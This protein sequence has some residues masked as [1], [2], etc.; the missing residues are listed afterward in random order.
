MWDQKF[1]PE[2]PMDS[3]FR[4]FF[5]VCVLIVFA[6]PGVAQVAKMDL[7]RLDQLAKWQSVYRVRTL[8]VHLNVKDMNTPLGQKW[9]QFIRSA[10]GRWDIYIDAYTGLPSLVN[11]SGIEWYRYEEPIEFDVLE[12]MARAFIRKYPLLFGGRFDETWLQVNPIR[13]GFFGETNELAFIDYD[14]IYKG[15]P[16]EGARL[17]FRLNHGR[18][19]QFG[20][21]GFRPVALENFDVIP[22]ISR[23]QA[24][25]ILEDYIGGFDQRTDHFIDG[26]HLII[27]PDTNGISVSPGKQSVIKGG[28]RGTRPTTLEAPPFLRYRL[29]WRL[30]FIRD[31]V[32][33]T[34][35]AHIDA[36]TGA[37]LE[38]FDDNKYGVVKG[39]V[40]PS[41]P[42]VTSETILPLPYADIRDSSGSLLE[43]ANSGGVYGTSSGTVK[44][45]LNG[46]YVKINDNCGSIS[47]STT[48]PGDLNFG[49]SSGTDCTTPGYGG[50]GN[51][52]SARSCFYHVNRIMEKGRAWLPSNNW[53][54][55]QLTS[56]VNI[57]SSCNAYWSPWQGTINFYRSGNG[58]GN[59]GEIAAIFL[60]EWGH[61]L[62]SNDG[63][64]PAELGTGEAYGD[65]VAFL[66]THESCIGP[67][68]LTNNCSG[69]GDSCLSCTGVRDVDY[70]KRA[71]GTPATPSNFIKNR[72]PT[73]SNYQGPC[74]REGHCES[75]VVSE[76]VWDLAARDLP[77][78]G[79]S[80]ATA[81]YIVDRL[82]YLTRTTSGQAFNC[83]N[84]S[85]NG[86]SAS[87]WYQTFL[88]ADDN[89]GDLSNGTPHG[90]EIYSAF[91][92]HG[93]ACGTAPGSSGCTA[94]SAPSLSGSAGNNSA[95]LSWTSVSGATK[96]VIL[97][98]DMGCSA[99]FT[100]VGETTSTS[101]TDSSV[102]N[103]FT[104]YYRVVAIGS[105]GACFSALSNC[106]TIT[107]TAG[108]A[109]YSISGKITSA[110]A[111]LSGV[112]VNYSGTASG[113]VTTDSTGSYTISNLANGTYTITPTKT[114]YT[115]TPVSQDVTV[116]N[117][118][119]TNV[120]FTATASTTDVTLTSGAPV[121]DSVGYQAW[122]Y[123]KIDV[124]AGATKLVFQTTNASADVDLYTRYGSKP[125]LSTYDCR[126][127]TSSGNETCTHNNPTSG[128]WWAGVYGYAAGSYTITATITS[129]SGSYTISGT[130][131]VN[132]SGLS[133]ATVTLSGDASATTTT[134]T[135]GYYE[136]TGVTNG[137]YTVTPS[138]SGY[139]FSPTSRNVNVNDASV[140]G[141]DFTASPVSSDVQL[142]N[143]TPYNDSL[144]ASSRNGTWKYYYVNIA[145]GS[146]NLSIS[147]SNLTADADLYVRYGS[148]PTL[149]SYDCRPYKGGTTTETC[150]FASP[151]GG[152]YWI[153]VTNWDTG[154]ISYTVT[155]S[156]TAPSSDTTPPDTTITSSQCGT[157]ISTNSTTITW[158]GSDNVTPTSNLVYN[159]RID[160]GTWSAYSTATSHTFTSLTD[161][162]HTVEVKAKDEAGNIDPTPASCTFTVD[163]TSTGD[164]ALSSGTP[165][166][167]SMTSTDTWKYYY[168]DVPSDAT[169]L[170]IETTNATADIDLYVR[171]NAKP[172]LSTYDCR[173]YTSSGNETCTFDSSTPTPISGGR[174]W[175]GIYNY[176]GA[177]NT[178]TVTA[179]YS[180]GNVTATYDSVLKVP[181]CSTPASSCSSGTLLDGRGTISGGA[182]PNY[183]NTINNSCADGN[184][185]TYHSDESID[186][187]EV[188]TTDGSLI[189]PG[190]SVQVKIT[191]YCYSTADSVDLYY[192]SDA[193]A[194]SW[195]YI[196]TANCSSSGLKTFTATVTLANVSGTH[197]V[198]AQI[199]YSGTASSCTTGNYNDH[200]DLAFV[201]Q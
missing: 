200:D 139:T 82:F 66:Q 40:Y 142:S 147:L 181:K 97:R 154:T 71:S 21:E 42:T 39:G 153:G 87:N 121:N 180:A 115:F 88:V 123:Y 157:T 61:G 29:V 8:P 31:G 191:A 185:G 80:S 11:G 91:S 18:L 167:D 122:K 44:S 70:A 14:I 155:A 114:G 179:T 74:G 20:A 109:T 194:P 161:G 15:I 17:I 184:S 75:Y 56:N 113:S 190:K 119:V 6:G 67:G 149:S 49:T 34:W 132:G 7:S 137:S 158:T 131:T 95:S 13:S 201:V 38:F 199:R 1:T 141:Q 78:A 182:E 159:Y 160:G 102:G 136:F 111:G 112:T 146:S 93:I 110:G 135:S 105:S 30:V 134:N 60:H 145:S 37:L 84:F 156:W 19:V 195:T 189:A 81:W 127:Y 32:K 90:N 27:L 168:I 100:K 117:N 186:Q 23:E 124:P 108:S 24:Q 143:G 197:A 33:G 28:K 5:F 47:L 86:C 101:Y 198:R 183:P 35:V 106:K 120:D 53:L 62:D 187:I 92:R 68:F 164:I 171:F 59:T 165:Y 76:A 173:P 2:V 48:A 125:T 144:T 148:K 72:C 63:V 41:S 3:R 176:A 170:I 89:D 99:G 175:I 96:Y 196:G 51:T 79:Y 36:R 178:Y 163:T 16:V 129:P 46:K 177:S 69:Y 58:C 64:A 73:S 162:S 26:G 174:W 193:N 22:D 118:N 94:M 130:I 172:T 103:G 138:K 57:N 152:T 10:G 12:Q 43:Y 50:T 166:D 77:N 151:N 169:Q 25:S 98:N 85:G 126:P 116:N 140:T 55:Q 83:S 192:T 9:L 107:P 128:W 54:Q 150:T 65:T 133:G 188:S 4:T 52:H 104:Y 45:Y